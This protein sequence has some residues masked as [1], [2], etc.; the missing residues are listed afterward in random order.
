MGESKL[1]LYA[2]VD[3][4]GNTGHNLFDEAQPDFFTAALI[5]KGDFDLT[6]G[7]RTRAIAQGLGTQE[8]HGKELGTKQLEAAAP[9]IIKLLRSAKA[10]FFVS[11]VEKRY[12]LA[13]KLFD[14]LFDSGE[15]AAVAWHNYNLRPLKLGWLSRFRS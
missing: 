14:S 5:T 10:H 11:R 12:L 8:L 9:D 2:Y 7:Q 1:P 4:T 6:F 3:E 15:N 13:T